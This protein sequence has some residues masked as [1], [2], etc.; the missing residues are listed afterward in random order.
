MNQRRLIRRRLAALLWTGAL[1]WTAA[2]CDD[3]FG[4]GIEVPE[5]ARIEVSGQTPVELLLVTSKR[6][7]FLWDEEAQR[8]TLVVAVA[9][10][11]PLM[12]DDLPFEKSISIR[13]EERLLVQLHNLQPDT[14]AVSLRVYLDGTIAY[15]RAAGLADGT[16]QYSQVWT[17]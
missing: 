9:D 17:R 6:F 3:F 12:Q 15:E 5:Q 10:T 1:A 14:A 7:A 13:P 8:D 2:A 11:I 4:V 16:F